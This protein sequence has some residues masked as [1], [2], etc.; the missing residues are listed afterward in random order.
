MRKAHFRKMNDLLQTKNIARQDLNV[1]FL[2]PKSVLLSHHAESQ[3]LKVGLKQNKTVKYP[4]S[5]FFSVKSLIS[6]V[7]IIL[8]SCIWYTTKSSVEGNLS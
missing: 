3:K 6:S 7:M 8:K 1:R 2:T 5:Y 4:G